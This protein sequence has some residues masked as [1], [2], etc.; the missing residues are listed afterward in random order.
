V[1]IRHIL[2]NCIPTLLVISTAS[3][4]QAMIVEA[5]LS[6]L[7]LGIPPPQPSWGGMLAAAQTFATRAP[8]LIVFP[9]LTI[10]LA[11]Y[12]FSVLGDALRDT[13]DPRLMRR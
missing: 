12:A 8:W 2:P 4:G 7:G 13:L 6:F 5:S 10:S 1:M 3:L 9:G 11:V